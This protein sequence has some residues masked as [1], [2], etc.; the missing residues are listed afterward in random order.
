MNFVKL[1]RLCSLPR[2]SLQRILDKSVTI[3]SVCYIHLTS[4]IQ[5]GDGPKGDPYDA[6]VKTKQL[7]ECKLNSERFP[8]EVT[9]FSGVICYYY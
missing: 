3:Q 4:C 1:P 7:Y 5:F 6:Y 8:I 2:F 9:L